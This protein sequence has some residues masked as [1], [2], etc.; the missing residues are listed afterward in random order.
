MQGAPVLSGTVGSMIAVLDAALINGFNVLAP[1]GISVT[2]SVATV[3]YAAN[4]G[5]AMHDIIKVAGA[6]PAELNGEQRVTWVNSTTLKFTTTA[7]DGAATGTL[8]TRSAPV[9]GWE[10]A[11]SGTNKAAY[12]RTDPSSTAMLLR[13]DDT[14]GRKAEATMYES[15][16]DVDTGVGATIAVWMKSSTA[17]AGVRKWRLIADDK[18]FYLACYWHTSYSSQAGV[19]AF[20][21]IASFKSGDAYHCMISG[22]SSE[23][24]TYPGYRNY[25]S[26][27]SGAFNNTKL[28]RSYTHIGAG[29][30]AGRLGLRNQDHIGSGG[31]T[32]PSSVD[33]SLLMHYP[34]VVTEPA[35]NA[36]RGTMPGLIQPIQSLPLVDGSVV[37]SIPQMPGKRVLLFGIGLGASAT[38]ARAAFDVTG[39]WR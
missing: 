7:A 1:S 31:F 20:G 17:D 12:R 13:I 36:A 27:Q 11:F 29:V 26:M 37:E 19:N 33:N 39:P 34:L 38:E 23:D 8:E 10:K 21:D 35:V 9:G 4:H 28:A 2:A 25:F 15:M 6:V 16:T 30:E 5:Y 3:T 32:F 18:L 14:A 24:Y 22:D